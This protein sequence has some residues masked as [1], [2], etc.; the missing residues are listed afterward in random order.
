MASKAGRRRGVV[1]AVA[2]I[3][4]LIRAEDGEQ[5]AF[6]APAVTG[7]VPFARLAPGQPVTFDVVRLL[8]GRLMRAVRVRVVP[9]RRTPPRKRAA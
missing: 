9:A 6:H 1:L 4:G 5:I 8:D 7:R 3:D 2:R